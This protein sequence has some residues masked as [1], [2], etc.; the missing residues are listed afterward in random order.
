[1]KTAATGRPRWGRWLY[2]LLWSVLQTAPAAGAPQAASASLA[3]AGETGV[4][5]RINPGDTLQVVVWREPELTRDLGV[6][7]DGRITMPLIGDVDAGGRAPQDLS[8]ELTSRLSRFI[9]APVVSVAVSQTNSLR[10]FVIGQVRTPG[11]FPLTSRITV[12]QALA[13]AGG[14]VEF[15]KT[16]KILVIREGSRASAIQVNYKKLESGDD[17]TQNI[18]LKPGD[19]VVVP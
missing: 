7:I 6:R 17:L 5:Y 1:M 10:V 18:A 11:G 12:L 19:T 2:A 13:L 15:A 9:E 8:R 4:E 14:F 3:E 16:D